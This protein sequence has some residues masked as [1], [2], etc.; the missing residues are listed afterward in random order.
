[1]SLSSLALKAAKTSM[2][3][4]GLAGG[5]RAGDAVILL[6][7]RVGAGGREVDLSAATFERQM[8]ALSRTGHARSLDAALEPGTGGVV[9]TF[10]DGYRDFSDHVLPRLVRYG[11]PALLYLQTGLVLEERAGASGGE[12]LS[13]SH[14]REA[15]ATGLVTVGAHT[16]THPDLSRASEAEAEE[17]M[18]RSKELIEDRLGLPCP[19]FAY[20]F[21]VASSGAERAARRLFRTAAIG[22]WKTNRCGRVDPHRLGRVPILRS[23]GAWLFAA[24]AGGRLNGEALLYRAFG[25]GP[26]RHG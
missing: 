16:H 21:A 24:K 14:L 18:R 17:E 6:Y 25:R 4:L 8:G 1:M 19:H 10:D 2:L 15:V 5:R 11:V 20:P 3:P 23:D 13:W 26:W 9:V 12:H 22:A 7:H